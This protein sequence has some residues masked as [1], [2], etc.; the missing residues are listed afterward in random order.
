[1]IEFGEIVRVIDDAIPE[2]CNNCG[3]Q[4]ELATEL[5][6][7]MIAKRII[8]HLGE[9]LV[10]EDGQEFDRLIEHIVP[11]DHAEQTKT[12]IRKLVGEDMNTIDERITMQRDTIAANARS[13]SGP[14]N[15]RAVKGGVRYTVNVCTSARVYIRDKQQHLPMHVTA[16]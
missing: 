3:V 2:Q 13:C 7:L 11:E 14:L 5:G 10:G 4:C 1:M 15:M 12:M 6:E 9:H 8:G 16:E